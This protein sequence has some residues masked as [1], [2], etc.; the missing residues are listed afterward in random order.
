MARANEDPIKFC[1]HVIYVTVFYYYHYKGIKGIII[2]LLA[3]SCNYCNYYDPIIIT[4]III[5]LLDVHFAIGQR[6]VGMLGYS[7]LNDVFCWKVK[8][9]TK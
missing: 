1:S 7:S 3:Y 2:I 4:I 9:Q 5:I 6:Y 8:R